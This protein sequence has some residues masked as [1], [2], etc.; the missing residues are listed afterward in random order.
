MD[1]VRNG[2]QEALISHRATFFLWG[3]IKNQVYSS[4]PATL[5]I[6]RERIESEFDRLKEQPQQIRRVFRAMR[7]RAIRCI[8]REGGHVEGY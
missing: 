2:P 8:E 3:R 7:K 1:F 6:L 5:E 4:L